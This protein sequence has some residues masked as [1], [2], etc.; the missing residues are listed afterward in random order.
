MRATARGQVSGGGRAPTGPQADGG[1]FG[2]AANGVPPVSVNVSEGPFVYLHCTCVRSA[3]TCLCEAI[4]HVCL[5][6]MWT[7]GAH[8]QMASYVYLCSASLWCAR[9]CVARCAPANACAQASVRVRLDTQVSRNNCS[10][11]RC[12]RPISRGTSAAQETRGCPHSA[13]TAPAGAGLSLS[14]HPSGWKALIT[15]R[16]SVS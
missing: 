2:A 10:A 7:C 5:L 1:T 15:H 11:S 12:L 8:T 16:N 6:P 3:R 9:L 14:P 13:P 4:W